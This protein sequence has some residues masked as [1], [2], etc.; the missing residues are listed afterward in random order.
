MTSSRN[1]KENSV[2]GAEEISGKEIRDEVRE[3]SATLDR[4]K[5]LKELWFL[6]RERKPLE[7]FMYGI[8]RI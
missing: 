3:D 5:T 6:P 8:D 1:I 7:S 4:V 2:P